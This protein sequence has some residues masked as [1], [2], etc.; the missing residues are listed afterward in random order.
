MHKALRESRVALSP[1]PI[2]L[3]HDDEL[4]GH[5]FFLNRHRHGLRSGP[6]SRR[7]GIAVDAAHVSTR[8]AARKP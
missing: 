8:P 3:L 6:S 1:P 7:T 2:P 5:R 4:L